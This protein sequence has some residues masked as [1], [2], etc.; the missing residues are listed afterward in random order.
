M[1]IAL[2]SD[3]AKFAAQLEELLATQSHVVSRLGVD[4]AALVLLRREPPAL[5]VLATTSAAAAAEFLRSL[6]AEEKLRLIPALGVN[7]RGDS[8]AGVA[9]L[10][11]GADDFINRPFNAQIF[12]ARARTLLRRRVWSGQLEEDS[13][14]VLESG[15]LRLRLIARQASADGK[16]LTL[17][18]L[19]FD[20]LAF[21]ARSPERVFSR[22]ELLEAV[23]N[24][25]GN[26]E[27]RTL[28]KHVETLRRKLGGLGGAIQTVHGVGYRYSAPPSRVLRS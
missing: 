22:H 20:L 26:V 2:A 21:F 25:P 18:R 8:S 23:W 19:E 13:V 7:P 5:V 12:L 10:D 14:A 28:D 1:L 15:P 17:T 4:A 9:L 6:R 24:Y 27:T 3:D 11:A 16:P